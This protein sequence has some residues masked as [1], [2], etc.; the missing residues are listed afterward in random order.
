[1]DDIDAVPEDPVTQAIQANWLFARL[2]PWVID[3]L[4]NEQ[5]EAIHQAALD[6]SWNRPPINI[7]FTIPLLTRRFFFTVVGGEEKRSTERRA[8]DRNRYPL[9]T[10]ANLFFGLGVAALFYVVVIMG[11]AVHSSIFEF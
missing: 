7:R 4:T 2:P 1:M 3:T 11:L 10:L 5:K 9:R 6:P 8:R